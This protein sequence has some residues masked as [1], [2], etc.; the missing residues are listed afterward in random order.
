MEKLIL[1]LKAGEGG[2]DSKLFMK[3]MAKMYTS[4]CKILGATQECL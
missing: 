1:E 3:D 4:Y 2:K